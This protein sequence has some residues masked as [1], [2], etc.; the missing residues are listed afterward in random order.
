MYQAKEHQYG[1]CRV[2][3]SFVPAAGFDPSPVPLLSNGH[4]LIF[5]HLS[6]MSRWGPVPI[7]SSLGLR[8]ATSCTIALTIHTRIHTTLLSMHERRRS[9]SAW[10]EPTVARGAHQTPEITVICSDS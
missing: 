8:W 3:Y 1:Y 7:P 4:S 5:Y 9:R 2:K 10:R 6:F